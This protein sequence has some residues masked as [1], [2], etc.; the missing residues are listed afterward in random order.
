MALMI[1]PDQHREVGWNKRLYH[2]NMDNKFRITYTSFGNS[3][4][5]LPYEYGTNSKT[6]KLCVESDMTYAYY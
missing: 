1:I 6:S 4:N 2:M 3:Y 5:L